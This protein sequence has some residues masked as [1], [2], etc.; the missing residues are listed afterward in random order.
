MNG[1]LTAAVALGLS[2]AACRGQVSEQPPIVIIRNMH[3]QQKYKPQERSRYFQDGRTMRPIPAHTVSREEGAIDPEFE[4]GL[5]AGT[6]NYLERIP[7]GVIAQ[8]RHRTNDG[9]WLEGGE[10]A[11]ARGRERF[12]IYCTPCHG[13]AGDGAGIV[14]A[15]SVGGGYQYPRPA[16][17]HDDRVRHLPDGQLY[18]TIRNGVRNMPGY[19][20][21]IPTHDRW[22]IVAYVRALQLSQA[23]AGATP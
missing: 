3:A 4:S 14:W 23:N 10:G 22:A 20:S 9:R 13:M 18:A 5:S 11:V 8:L 12:N 17:L 16:T 21:Q 19:A 7:Q 15:R 1:R 6:R 2:L